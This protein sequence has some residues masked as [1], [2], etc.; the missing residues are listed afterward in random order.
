[1]IMTA[2]GFRIRMRTAM[3][4]GNGM[5]RERVGYD[6]TFGVSSFPNLLIRAYVGNKQWGWL[7]RLEINHGSGSLTLGA[8][9]RFH[10]S[11]HWGKI[12]TPISFPQTMTRTF[13]F[14]NTMDEKIL[15]P[16]YGHELYKLD[17]R[18]TAMA[19]IQFAYTRYAIE[20]ENILGIIFHFLISL[21]IRG[22]DLIIMSTNAS[23]YTSIL[24]TLLAKPRLT[25]LYPAEEA[26]YG[27][28]PQFAADT[29]A[30]E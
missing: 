10:H 20:N 23:M 1:M 22:W 15:S 26:Y 28:T 3:H 11:L 30:A 9:L 8:E 4:A 14:M 21:S 12:T 25:D 6:S 29:A 13:T 16:L 27:M 24:L 2:I 19:D 17:D 5:F 7:P 18:M